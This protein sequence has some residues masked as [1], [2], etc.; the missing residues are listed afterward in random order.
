MRDTGSASHYTA[1]KYKNFRQQQQSFSENPL[2]FAVPG[3]Y[4]MLPENF[5]YN[6]NIP[7]AAP[8]VVVP[9]AAAPS[10]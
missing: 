5:G 8:S 4:P 3:Q 6:I 10:E 9:P 7:Q 2:G 1:E